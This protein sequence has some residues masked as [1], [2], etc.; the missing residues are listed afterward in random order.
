MKTACEEP[1][2]RL[3]VFRISRL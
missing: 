2:Y 1:H 3:T